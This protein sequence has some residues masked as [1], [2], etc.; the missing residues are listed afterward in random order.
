MRRRRRRSLKNESQSR[1]DLEEPAVGAAAPDLVAGE[2]AGL[3]A[4]HRACEAIDSGDVARAAG[5]SR[6]MDLLES[7]SSLLHL[8]AEMVLLPCRMGVEAVV[9]LA[10]QAGRATALV[11]MEALEQH[12]TTAAVWHD[13]AEALRGRRKA[14]VLRDDDIGEAFD[15]RDVIALWKHWRWRRGL[16]NRFEEVVVVVVVVLMHGEK[17]WFFFSR[18]GLLT[19]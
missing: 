2:E 5:T 18:Y 9:A 1:F 8:L 10:T 12:R 4:R 6:I 11:D 17:S 15:H 14:R 19:P 16:S 3:V 7:T 13:G